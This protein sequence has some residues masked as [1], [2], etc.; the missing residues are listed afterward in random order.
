MSDRR[1]SE[2]GALLLILSVIV[3][4]LLSVIAMIATSQITHANR[5]TAEYGKL[6]AMNAA[7]SGIFAAFVATPSLSVQS[8]ASLLPG[9]EPVVHY[10]ATVSAAPP[11]WIESTGYATLSGFTYQSKAR[12]EVADGRIVRWEFG[13]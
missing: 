13:K 11:Y 1:R 5:V 4:A 6:Q 7:E 12:A 10:Q 3:F 9:D 8:A 2:R